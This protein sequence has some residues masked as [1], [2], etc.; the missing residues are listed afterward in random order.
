MLLG[1]DTAGVI[2]GV[3]TGISIP[4]SM[5]DC[6]MLTFYLVSIGTTSGGT[7]ALE[8]ADY[9]GYT[10][11]VYTGTWSQITTAV[12]ASSFTGGKQF[13]YHATAPSL[14]SYVRANI[15]ATITGGGSVYVVLRA[16]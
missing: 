16:R 3:T 1:T 9:D 10:D 13:A 7:I 11:G 6:T 12:T 4:I 15:T 8:E 5:A 14:F 2:A